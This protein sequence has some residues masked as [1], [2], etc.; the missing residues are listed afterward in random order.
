MSIE[1]I[2]DFQKLI[3]YNHYVAV[4]LSLKHDFDIQ[5]KRYP[6]GESTVTR[7]LLPWNHGRGKPDKE[8]NMI[9]YYFLWKDLRFHTFNEFIK[10]KVYDWYSKFKNEIN[11]N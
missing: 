4:Q 1:G 11:I 5:D 2:D 7:N 9:A 6:L 3:V 10:E 8:T